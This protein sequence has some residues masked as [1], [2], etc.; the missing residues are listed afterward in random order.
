MT[1][2]G[3]ISDSAE[4]QTIP[5]KQHEQAVTIEDDISHMD[6][7]KPHSCNQNTHLPQLIQTARSRATDESYSDTE[8]SLFA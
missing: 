4:D 6:E 8:P 1:S 5:S 7:R 2:Q 3:H